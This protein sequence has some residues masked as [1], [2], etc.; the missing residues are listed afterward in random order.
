MSSSSSASAMTTAARKYRGVRLRKWGKWVSEIRLPNSRERIW[1]GSYDTPEEAARAF[2]AAFVCLRGG[3]GAAEAAGINFP[4]SPP[5]VVRTSD[6]QE[7]HAAAVSHANRPPSS[8]SARAMP[9]AELPLEDQEATVAADMAAP[10]VVAGAGNAVAPSSPVNLSF[11]WSQKPLYSPTS[12]DLQRWMTAQEVAEE[13]IME[14]DDEGTSDNLWS[15]HYSPT[16]SNS[17]IEPVSFMQASTAAAEM[18]RY[19]GVR[20]RQWGKWAAEIRLPNSRK[21]IW[22]GSYD[23]PEKAA[24]AFDAAFICLRGAEAIA[25]LN[26][27]ESPPPPPPP[28]VART[29]NLRDQVYAFAV[30]HANRPPSAEAPAGI[31]VP[32]AQVAAEESDDDAV[33]GNAAPPLVH[34]AAASLDD[35]SQFMANPPPMYSPTATTAGSQAIWPHRQQNPTVRMTN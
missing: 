16:H 1:L 10:D 28:A 7:V 12:L 9:D 33:R 11:D 8:A 27:P 15:F 14:A 29:G 23:T 35:W 3:A 32:A 17:E 24:R 19:K 13:S 2:D 30:S 22:L 4:D 5:A 26:F 21:R 20:L 25:G 18:R 6:T 31:V 34:V